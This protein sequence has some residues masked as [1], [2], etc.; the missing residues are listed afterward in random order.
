MDLQTRTKRVAELT[1]EVKHWKME[2]TKSPSVMQRQLTDRLRADLLEKEKQQQALSKALADLRREFINQAEQ[3]AIAIAT[4]PVSVSSIKEPTMTRKI[5]GKPV[6]AQPNARTVMGITEKANKEAPNSTAPSLP[7]A[8]VVQLETENKRL[9]EEC[10]V[11][12]AQLDRLKQTRKLTEENQLRRQVENLISKNRLLEG[13]NRSL[14]MVPEKPYQETVRALR[15]TAQAARNSST[16]SDW[17]I[18]KQLETEVSRLRTQSARLN[19]DIVQLQNQLEVNKHALERVTRENETL[20]TRVQNRWGP[21]ALPDTGAG[22][23]TTRSKQPADVAERVSLHE[24]VEKL[25]TEVER[26]RRAERISAELPLGVKTVT[27]QTMALETLEMRNRIASDRIRALEQQLMTKGLTTENNLI[28][29]HALQE[30]ILRLNKENLEQRFELE[31]LR[32][33]VPRLKTRVHDLQ[34]YVDVL[35][36]EKEALRKGLPVDRA[37]TP[38]STTMTTIKRLGESGKSTKELEQ[39]IVRLKRVLQRTQ[40]ENERLKCAPGPVSHEE[41]KRL[42]AENEHLR[43]ELERAQLVAGARLNAKRLN[44]EKSILRLS[45]E[46]E[47]LRKS[48]EEVVQDREKTR[49]ELRQTRQSG[50]NANEE[51]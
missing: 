46:Y 19:S 45:Q 49:A 5:A 3:S 40:A 1:E 26:L 37:H 15:D 23:G 29:E 28:T 39:I 43:A 36:A 11:L 13:E 30:D 42:Q 51:E 41:T 48:Y 47:N 14:R 7:S 20:R 44:T 34:T 38:D 35:K 27:D 21:G 22:P 50:Q 17:D 32:A 25:K 6:N 16:K 4:N 12:K 10:Q 33:D 31:T 8:R 18:R 24:Q 2:A 9:S